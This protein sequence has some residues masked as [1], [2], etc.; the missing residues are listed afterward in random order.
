MGGD[1]VVVIA[2][3]NVWRATVA[4]LQVR[5]LTSKAGPNRAIRGSDY[6]KSPKSTDINIKSISNIKNL[7]SAYELIKSNP[8]NMTHG[9]DKTTL[10]GITMKTL[11]KIQEELKAGRYEFNPARRIQIPK[12]G[13]NE[14]RPLTIA[15]PREKIV[16]KAI[17]L[18]LEQ[19]YEKQFLESSHGFRPGKGTH[20][21]MKRL[22][23]QFQSVH[24]IIEADFSKAFDTIQHKALLGIIKEDIKCEKTIKL[25]K[26]GLKAGYV[27]FG[28]LHDNLTMGT[29]QGSIL[30]PLLCNIYLNKLDKF[31]EVIKIESENGTKRKKNLEYMKIQNKTKYWRKKGYDISKPVEYQEMFR[32]LTT[33]PSIRRDES[34]TRIQ[35][36]RYADDFVIGVE[37]SYTMTK[38]ILQRVE[39]FVTKELK[40]KFNPEKTGI[41]NYSEKPVDFLGFKIK[42][43]HLKG[44][45]KP[46]ENIQIGDKLIQRRKKIKVRL[47][48]D[49]QKVLNKLINNG[50]LRKRKSHSKHNELTYRGTFKGNLINLD[51]ADII[52]YYNAVARGLANYYSFVDNRSIVVWI[53]WLI[54]ESCG[55]TLARK[56]KLKTLASVFRKF[57]KNLTAKINE[58]RS[59]SFIDIKYRPP[60]KIFKAVSVNKDPLKSLDSVWNAKF[61]K[62]NIGAS[63]VICGSE[64][65]VEIHHV[66]KIWDKKKSEE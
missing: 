15:S 1:G 25:I 63:C 65:N 64:D 62:S 59:I 43:P 19:F 9:V 26:S 51:H 41:T 60:T 52:R 16:Q 28:N 21:A 47:E 55:L 8:E 31:M 49:V 33:I 10:D 14:T 27:E 4:N 44:S 39:E 40:L 11:H 24:F 37:G 46:I 2:C 32:L 57:G 18:V 54:K 42:A 34:F 61:T 66:R 22:E 50:F 12:F 17:L 20:T 38:E 13:K 58:S 53:E 3:N 5:T 36:V 35:Y 7:V 45:I 48:M 30:S 56:F 29:P 23:A 6:K